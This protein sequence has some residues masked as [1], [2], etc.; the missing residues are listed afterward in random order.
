MFFSYFSCVIIL[1]FFIMS[2]ALSKVTYSPK[3]YTPKKYRIK[4]LPD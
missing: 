4:T 3:Y 1:I 2:S